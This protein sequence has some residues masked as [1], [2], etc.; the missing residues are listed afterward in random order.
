M[1]PFT[2]TTSPAGPEVGVSTIVGP[3]TVNVACAKSPELPVTVI[4]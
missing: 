4:T 3:I 2:V 1:L